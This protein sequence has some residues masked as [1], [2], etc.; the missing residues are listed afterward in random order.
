MASQCQGRTLEGEL[1]SKSIVGAQRL[2]T[3]SNLKGLEWFEDTWVGLKRHCMATGLP[4]IL[5]ST[6][7]NLISENALRDAH[8]IVLEIRRKDFCMTSTIPR[9]IAELSELRS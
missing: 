6:L 4:Q 9:A 5:N 3:I 8:E 1:I 7:H 2:L